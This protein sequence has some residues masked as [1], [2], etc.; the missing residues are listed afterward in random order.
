[1]A[2]DLVPLSEDERGD[3]NDMSAPEE[4]LEALLKGMRVFTPGE[5]DYRNRSLFLTRRPGAIFLYN[6]FSEHRIVFHH[7]T[8]LIL[9]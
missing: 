3:G 7:K 4:D 1:M 6:S 2:E 5:L 9:S 8:R